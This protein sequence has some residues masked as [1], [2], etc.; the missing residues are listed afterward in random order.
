MQKLVESTSRIRSSIPQLNIGR[1][2]SASF[3][4]G[5]ELYF[6]FDLSRSVTDESLN[7]SLAFA[8]QLV[9]RVSISLLLI[10]KQVNNHVYK[11]QFC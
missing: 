10:A 7:H 11:L 2:I 6:L 8:I 9:E 1:F 4:A 5:H 3:S